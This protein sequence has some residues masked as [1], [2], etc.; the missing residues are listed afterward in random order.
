MAEAS[1]SR[2]VAALALRLLASGAL[3]AGVGL[4]AHLPLGA[5]PDEAGL[6]VDLRTPH[7]KVEIC[8]ERGAEELAALP[9]HM[10]QARECR[11]TAIDYRLRIAVD[12]VTLLDRPVRHR[13]VRR[14]RPLLAGELVRV[15]PGRHEVAIDFAPELPAG[16]AGDAGALRTHRL[17]GS[18][19]LAAGRV[20]VAA[21]DAGELRWLPPVDAP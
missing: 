7:A 17:A 19:D 14:N 9:A 13:G 10:R 15:A 21:L 12:G 16:F 20:A 5:T 11:E 4:L 6:R 2:A 3:V 18:V 1:R 8:E